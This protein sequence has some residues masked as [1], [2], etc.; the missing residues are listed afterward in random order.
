MGCTFRGLARM[1]LLYWQKKRQLAN[2]QH[3]G[4]VKC[5]P[6]FNSSF[7]AAGDYRRCGIARF[8]VRGTR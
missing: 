6:A 2:K 1:L 4:T 8:A 3:E 7:K 5:Q